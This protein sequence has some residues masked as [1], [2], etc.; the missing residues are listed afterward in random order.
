MPYRRLPNTDQ[1][2]IRAMKMALGKAD[3]YD[4]PYGLPF[5]FKT[6]GAVRN[7]LPRFDAAHAFYTECFERQAKAGRK[8]QTHVK[9]AR[10]YLSHFIQVLNLA[11]IRSEIRV[12]HKSYYGLDDQHALP[13][14][15]GEQSLLE[16]GSK[17]VDGENRRISQGGIPIYN[18]TIAKVKV[19]YDIFADSYE[20]QRELQTATTR[21]L[22][23]VSAMR[24]EADA[25]ILDLWN[26]IEENFSGIEPADKRLDLCRSYGVVYYY[27]TSEKVKL[28]IEE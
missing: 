23:A 22:E 15:S 11:V 25:L 21:S 2:R 14:L 24:R 9:M 20:R 4:N 18:P 3:S 12:A 7:F 10:L 5:S 16:W 8:H 6:V 17:I 1:A 28:G 19:H 13:D 26:Q 27:R